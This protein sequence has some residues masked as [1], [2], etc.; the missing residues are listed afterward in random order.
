MSTTKISDSISK[1]KK[2]KSIKPIYMILLCAL[3]FVA[4]CGSDDNPKPNTQKKAKG[5]HTDRSK[6]IATIDAASSGKQERNDYLDE[7][8]TKSDIQCRYYLD[9]PL[10]RSESKSKSALYMNLFDSISAVFGTKDITDS[11][12]QLYMK[13]PNGPNEAKI[14]Y[15]QALSSEIKRGVEIARERYAQSMLIKKNRLIESY[16]VDMLEKDIENYDKLCDYEYGLMEINNILKRA[17]TPAV[18]QPF[19]SKLKIDPAAIKHK[20]ETV[21]IEAKNKEEKKK[22]KNIQ[23]EEEMQII[24]TSLNNNDSFAERPGI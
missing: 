21:T 17:Q 16:T 5:F 13:N 22:K 8:I 11:A 14:A 15:E 7:F 20:V 10:R 24:E 23:S 9:K 4:G 1:E 2:M 12:K 18:L 3:W 6:F 19:S